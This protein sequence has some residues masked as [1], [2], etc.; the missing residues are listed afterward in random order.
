M[1][2]S[3]YNYTRSVSTY[4]CSPRACT[5]EHSHAAEESMHFLHV[6][7]SR[8]EGLA[9]LTTHGHEEVSNMFPCW[10]NETI[11]IRRAL[12]EKK[13]LVTGDGTSGCSSALCHEQK[14]CMDEEC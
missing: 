13:V 4:N 14:C 1:D 8:E 12:A 9:Q 5:P 10:M 6:E 7:S 11:H 2:S 3:Q